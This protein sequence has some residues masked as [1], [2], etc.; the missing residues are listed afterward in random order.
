MTRGVWE[1]LADQWAL[2][3]GASSGLGAEFARQLAGLADVFVNDA[4]GSWQPHCSTVDVTR[5]LPSFAG[6][7]MQEEIACLGIAW[8][9][10]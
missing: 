7:L 2:V 6:Y 3:T 1:H 9:K 8:P 5:H 10:W 4:F